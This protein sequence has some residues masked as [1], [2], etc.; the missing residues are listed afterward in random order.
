MAKL[1]QEVIWQPQPG[2][3][4]RLVTC[5]VFEVFFGGARGGG[6]TDA[7]IGDWL[8]HSN[9]YGVH[10]IGLFIRRTLTQ[11][12]EVIARTKYLFPKIGAKYNEKKAEWVMPNGARLKF[13][14]LERDADASNYQGHNYTRIYVEEA[15]DFP[16]IDPINKL[17]GTL[18]SA[19]GV[20]CGMRLTGNPGG[21]GHGWLKH[22][23]IEP[24]RT[25][26][27]VITEVEEIEI[28]G[29]MRRVELSRVFI[30]SK[31]QDNK[32]LLRNN[33]S[34][35]L[36]LKQTG[37]E[38]LVKAWLDGDWDA[39]EGAF[40]SEF[41]TNKHVLDSDIIQ[42]IP[43]KVMRFRSFDWGSSRPFS[44]GWW[45]YSDGTFGFPKD[46]LIR[47]KEWYGAKGPNIGLNMTAKEVADGIKLRQKAEI[48]KYGVADPAIFIQ[49]GG[50]SIGQTMAKYG[51]AWKKADNERIPGWEQIR[52][53]LKGIDGVPLIYFTE[54]CVDTISIIPSL[55]HDKNDY[56]DLDTKQEDHIAD[57]IRYACMSRPYHVRNIQTQYRNRD[58]TDYFNCTISEIVDN[59]K[60]KRLQKENW[61]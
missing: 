38:Q 34:Y 47:Y 50:P 56:E 60:R 19:V 51:V 2:P 59:L 22:R 48:I 30:P 61:E 53:R 1:K 29:E 35:L 20:P 17:K 26:Y 21:P 58:G 12:A 6:K 43:K 24:C 57:E 41:D 28:D 49:N 10:A 44:V 54:N 39:V 5:P 3:Q 32:L 42:Y 55:Q 11:L 52:I 15:G 14:Y 16:F 9:Q 36:Q 33:P 13:A 4:T 7:S 46:A 45:V 18:R 37:S 23:Y 40:F 8:Q 31:V 25:G 27:K